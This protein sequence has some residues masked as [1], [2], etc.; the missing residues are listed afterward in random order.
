MMKV[1]LKIATRY[2][3]VAGVLA[4]MLLVV[5]YYMGPHP[6]LTSPFLDFRVLLFGIFTFFTLKEYRDYHGKG[7]L[8]YWQAMY[9]GLT[10]VLV[11]TAIT[12]CLL[13]LFGNWER[14]FVVSYVAQLA[15]YLQSFPQ[16]DIDRIGKEVYER[17]LKEL[18]ATNVFDLVQTYFV[19]GTIIGFF[20]TIIIS[21]ILRR[22][23]KP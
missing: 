4:F 12:S 23:S 15:V 9:G 6:L 1:L 2:G 3:F 8:Y 18:P 11:S 19:Q 10:M 5:M 14:E 22:Q 20:V 16:E 7:I 17:N 13:W 21:V